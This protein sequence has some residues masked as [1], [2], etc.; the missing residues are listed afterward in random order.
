VNK[1]DILDQAA[2]DSLKGVSSNDHGEYTRWSCGSQ[3]KARDRYVWWPIGLG[4]RS[5]KPQRFFG[6]WGWQIGWDGIEQRVFGQ[7]I[8]I[9]SLLIKLGPVSK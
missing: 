6:R 2:R 8:R 1:K 5:D 3:W 9:G 4:W 7:T